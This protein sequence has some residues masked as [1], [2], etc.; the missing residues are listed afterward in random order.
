MLL[1]SHTDD[2]NRVRLH[3]AAAAH[4]GDWLNV[5]L[6]SLCALR[7]ED[8]ANRI[9]VGLRLGANVCDSHDFMCG[10]LVDCR[11]SVIMITLFIV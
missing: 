6:I 10:L 9:A 4:S 7:L 1:K 8:E 11:G 5:L 2:Y 3:A